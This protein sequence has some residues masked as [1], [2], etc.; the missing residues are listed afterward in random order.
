MGKKIYEFEIS[1]FQRSFIFLDLS[2][3]HSRHFHII[4]QHHPHHLPPID[5]ADTLSTM[6]TALPQQTSIELVEAFD[7]EIKETELTVN[8]MNRNKDQEAEDRSTPLI[9]NL[10]PCGSCISLLFFLFLAGSISFIYVLVD[11]YLADPPRNNSVEQSEWNNRWW[12]IPRLQSFFFVGMCCSVS[13]VVLRCSR[14][15]K[16][17]IFIDRVS[18][19]IFFLLFLTLVVIQFGFPSNYTKERTAILSDVER[20]NCTLIN[21]GPLS[22]FEDICPSF[23]EG[24]L[25][26]LS[27][28]VKKKLSILSNKAQSVN[29]VLGTIERLGSYTALLGSFK[30]PIE[31]MDEI[32]PH[33]R[34][35][36]E[37]FDCVQHLPKIGCEIV[38]SRCMFS[39]CAEVPGVCFKFKA[40]VYE[41]WRMCAIEKCENERRGSTSTSSHVSCELPH[42]IVYKIIQRVSPRQLDG[43]AEVVSSLEPQELIIVQYL[44]DATAEIAAGMVARNASETTTVNKESDCDWK[45]VKETTT[46]NHSINC[47][48]NVT[49]YELSTSLFYNDQ[50]HVIVLTTVVLATML[51]CS[52]RAP[53]VPV[54][55]PIRLLSSFLGMLVSL[56]IFAGGLN[57]ERASQVTTITSYQRTELEG[58]SS[59]YL[60]ISWACLNHALFMVFPEKLVHHTSAVETLVRNCV[61]V[62][63]LFRCCV[64]KCRH[65]SGR[66]KDAKSPQKKNSNKQRKQSATSQRMLKS[67]K[68]MKNGMQY[69]MKEVVSTRGK[70]FMVRMLVKEIMESGVQLLGIISTASQTDAFFV[71]AMGLLVALNL[72]VLNVINLLLRRSYGHIVA[73]GA[74]VMTESLF[75]KAF[76]IMSVFARD[77]LVTCEVGLPWY[78]QLLRH[79][80]TLIPAISFS[81][82]KSSFVAL[83]NEYKSSMEEAEKIENEYKSS[84]GE[85]GKLKNKLGLSSRTRIRRASSVAAS[86]YHEHPCVKRTV[87]I[88]SPIIIII[89]LILGIFITSIIFQ[90]Q[91]SCVKMVGSIAT[92]MHPALYFRDGFFHPMTCGKLLY[93]DPRIL[94]FW[95]FSLLTRCLYLFFSF[96][97]FSSLLF[98]S[99]PKHGEMCRASTAPLSQM[100]CL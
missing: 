40:V 94:G 45:D 2:C 6:S 76:L 97:F 86:S 35:L 87:Q 5:H 14:N 18:H 63:T 51:V 84:M 73:T 78:E 83:F 98:S 56:L 69:M 23:S 48:A 93:G 3:P 11:I 58:W 16:P 34:N 49:K 88:V 13:D 89:G 70:W 85:A 22:G 75:D 50:S 72:V 66:S 25:V 15:N 32:Y 4:S 99:L 8:P 92:C 91:A 12:S 31:P 20:G 7:G 59:V 33:A 17:K 68:S 61:M 29:S 79:G 95:I 41:R 42:S 62:R 90:Q 24:A 65:R 37:D 19:E 46:S 82:N 52:M 10:S 55:E 71:F 27:T 54:L 80:I 64:N 43:V 47:D 57:V 30:H 100:N 44:V 38:F 96:L 28:G 77:T 21:E 60:F 36:V 26:Q 9:N 74:V 53:V 39:N 81:L 1:R 67:Q